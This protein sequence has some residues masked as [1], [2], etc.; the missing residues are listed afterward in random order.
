V[1][2]TPISPPLVQQSV[3]RVTALNCP[4]CGANLNITAEMD[5]FACGHRGS[6]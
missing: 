5:T 2:A 3:N 4:N 6:R 1:V